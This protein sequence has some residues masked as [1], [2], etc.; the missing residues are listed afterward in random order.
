MDQD[1]RVIILKDRTYCW[2][3]SPKNISTGN[4]GNMK[5][6]NRP[7]G[8]QMISVTK[9][10]TNGQPTTSLHQSYEWMNVGFLAVQHKFILRIGDI[11]QTFFQI[12]FLSDEQYVF[13]HPLD[14]PPQQHIHTLCSNK[15]CTYSNDVNNIFL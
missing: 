4:H 10:P 5:S 6:L 11:K 2:T 1:Y 3:H 13:D 9:I 12:L 7:S 8:V 15:S 14:V